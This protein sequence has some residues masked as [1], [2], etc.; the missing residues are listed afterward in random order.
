MLS[1]PF[2]SGMVVVDELGMYSNVALEVCWRI[3][4]IYKTMGLELTRE[5]E[6]PDALYIVRYGALSVFHRG[7][8]IGTVRAGDVIGE[9]DLLGFSLGGFRTRTTVCISMCELCQLSKVTRKT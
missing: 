2:F 8:E 4:S 5:G 3:R 9:M 7:K 6:V 1:C